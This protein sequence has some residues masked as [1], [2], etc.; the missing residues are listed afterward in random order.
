M[1]KFELK[2]SPKEFVILKS[3]TSIEKLFL[4]DE[5][6]I[7]FIEGEEEYLLCNDFIKESLDRLKLFLKQALKNLKFLD[8][9]LNQDIGYMWNEVLQDKLPYKVNEELWVGL[10]FSLWEGGDDKKH[11]ATWLYNDPDGNIVMHITENYPWHFRKKGESENYI[12]YNEFIR[13]YKPILIRIIPHQ[14]ARQWL[15]QCEYLLATVR[16]NEQR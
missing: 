7:V 11:F 8:S 16:E 15:A 2:I 10:C 1:K 12:S 9:S 6:T 4:F 13:N 5:I 3:C 14:V